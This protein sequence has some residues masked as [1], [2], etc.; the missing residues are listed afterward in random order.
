M[1]G[2]GGGFGNDDYDD[3]I[4]LLRVISIKKKKSV[5]CVHKPV[6]TDLCVRCKSVSREGMSRQIAQ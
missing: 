5:T 1:A 2:G 6:Q 3:V 4:L